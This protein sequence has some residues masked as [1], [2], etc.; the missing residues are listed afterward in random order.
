MNWLKKLFGL[1]EKEEPKNEIPEE[2]DISMGECYSCGQP[3]Y[4]SQRYSK[5][6]GKLFHKKCYNEMLR[7]F[8]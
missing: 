1:K 6:Q 8:K 2:A 5:Q 3:V 4:R 7:G